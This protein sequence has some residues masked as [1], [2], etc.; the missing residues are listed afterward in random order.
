MA[1]GDWT[2]RGD[3]K[4]ASAIDRAA[5]RLCDAVHAAR[6]AGL[7]VYIH[8]PDNQEGALTFDA[9]SVERPIPLPSDSRA[10]DAD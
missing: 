5:D 1:A 3:R 9:F 10:P 2:A 8:I 7:K 4:L 6:D